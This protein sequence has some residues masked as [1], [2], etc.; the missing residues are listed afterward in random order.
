MVSAEGLIPP[1]D[2]RYYAASI[3]GEL[4]QVR[5]IDKGMSYGDISE[6]HQFDMV[7]LVGVIYAVFTANPARI[8]TAILGATHVLAIMGRPDIELV[9]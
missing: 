3:A 9:N 7:L 2:G 5:V 6:R 8:F 1:A 4:F